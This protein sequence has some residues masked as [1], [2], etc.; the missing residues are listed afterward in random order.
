[1]RYLSA[2]GEYAKRILSHSPNAPSDINLAYIGEIFDWN[3]KIRR[4]EEKKHLKL[5]SLS[6]FSI[7][8]FLFSFPASALKRSVNLLFEN[9]KSV[10]CFQ[11]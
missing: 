9:M 2:Y 6:A 4:N 3:K 11:A 5:L 10:V 8:L 1:M 7:F